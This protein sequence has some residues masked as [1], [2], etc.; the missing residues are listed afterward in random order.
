MSSRDTVTHTPTPRHSRD[1]DGG[2]FVGDDGLG[3]TVVQACG[4]E[5]VDTERVLTVHRA[6]T[7]EALEG[8]A[9][10]NRLLGCAGC[11]T[12]SPLAASGPQTCE[13]RRHVVEEG[14][15]K[16]TA[17]RDL[18]HLHP[19]CPDAKSEAQKGHLSL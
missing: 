1:H 19:H 14:V 3:L 7:L 5:G 18:A 15:G 8:G 13:M 11:G 2:H 10:R 6:A 16:S 9:R 4:L 17:G 12:H